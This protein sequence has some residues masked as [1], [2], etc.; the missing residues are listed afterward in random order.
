M[1]QMTPPLLE[2]QIWKKYYKDKKWLAISSI[3]V[4]MTF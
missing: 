2:S 3:L 1:E 4:Q